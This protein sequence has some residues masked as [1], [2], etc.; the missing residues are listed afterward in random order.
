VHSLPGHGKFP[1]IEIWM[2]NIQFNKKKFQARTIS[3][4]CVL[5]QR[6][7]KRFVILVLENT[8]NGCSNDEFNEEGAR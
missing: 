1:K 5:N 8:H 7:E 2:C 4:V 3:K 6:L